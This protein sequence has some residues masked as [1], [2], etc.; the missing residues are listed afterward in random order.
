M[1]RRFYMN[2]TARY[3][4]IILQ[5]LYLS[6]CAEEPVQVQ[7]IGDLTPVSSG[8]IIQHTYYTLAYSEANEQAEWVYYML[9]PEMVAG[10]VKRK[11]DFR[12]DPMVST[13]S[14]SL[15]DY[16]GSGYDRGHLCPAA[17]MSLNTASMSESFFMS[18]MS[19][20]HPS[21]NRGKWKSLETQV[22]DWVNIE[23]T[24]YVASGAIFSN[25]KGTIGENRVTVPGYYYKVIL[26]ITKPYKMIAFIM[27][28]EKMDN[29]ID[30]YVTTVD[31][32]EALTSIN[33]FPGIPDDLENDLE[34]HS[35]FVK[36]SG[37]TTDPSSILDDEVVVTTDPQDNLSQYISISNVVVSP[38]ESESVTLI[39]SSVNA[40]DIGG[41]IIGDKNDPNAYTIPEGTTIEGNSTLTFSHNILGFGINNSDEIIY[42]KDDL[43]NVV[44]TW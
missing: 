36:W 6:A 24:L 20:Q 22:R 29:D 26:D 31:S 9:T 17:S 5:I 37:S 44:D 13:G 23:D 15:A 39:N 42:L 35:D 4:L 18:N 14:A 41:W 10:N 8:Q 12:E 27:P 19:P 28:N 11:D 21:C 32:I 16:V 43:G 25:N 34:S 3:L 38:T 2:T 1:D 40:V 33:F 30:Y 7:Q